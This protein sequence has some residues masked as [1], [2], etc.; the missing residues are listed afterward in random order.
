MNTGG[1][2]KMLTDTDENGDYVIPRIIYS[3]AYSSEMVAYADLILPD[4]TYLER[5]D[6]ISLLDRPICEADAAA[7]AIRWPVIEPDRNVRGFQSVLCDLGARLG[8]PAF[9]NADGGQKYADYADY[10]TSHE[11]RP[12]IGPLAGFRGAA[13]DEAGRGAPNPDQLDR[14]IENGGFFVNHIPE[15]ANYYKPWNTAYQDWAVGMG[16]YDAPQPYIFDLYVEP[17]RKFQLA[18]EG[19]GERQPPEHLRERIKATL[20]PLPIWYPPFEDDHVDTTEFPVH[21][22]TQR[23]MAMYHSWGSQNA[24]LRQIHGHNPLYLPTKLWEKNGFADGDWARV[25]SAHGEIT[26]PVAHMAALNENTIWT[27]NAIGKRKGAWAL[28]EDAPEATKGF[29]LNHLIHELLP[30]KG[31]GLRWSNSDPV[32]GQAAWFDLRV[33]V[34]KTDAPTESQPAMKPLKSPVPQ[35]PDHLEWKVGK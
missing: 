13:G 10:I 14:Y 5:H 15:G 28:S 27:W 23:P 3:D 1:V 11:R 17:L 24:W 18:A 7:D 33:K 30:P 6:C 26:V 9:T 32:T 19:H 29:L 25:T 31:D 34:E 21:A 35:G 12:G 8:L 4:T 2:I 16:I 20:D 22:L